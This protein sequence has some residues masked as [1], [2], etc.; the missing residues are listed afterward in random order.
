[1]FKIR[2]LGEPLDFLGILISRDMEEGT[3]TIHQSD[4]AL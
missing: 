3:I 4:K 2:E 1:M